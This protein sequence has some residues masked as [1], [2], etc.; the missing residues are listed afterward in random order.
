MAQHSSTYTETALQGYEKAI[1]RFFFLFFLIQLLPID[2]AYWRHLF[3]I[4]WLDLQY[5]DIFYL[6]RYQPQ[7]LPGGPSFA[8]W[9]ITA[10]LALVGSVV[11][12]TRDQALSHYQAAYYWLRVALRYRLALAVLAYGF[13]KFFP[14]QAPPPSLSHLNT[15]YGDFSAWKLF[16]L[17][18]GVV[19]GYQSFLGLVEIAG[20]LLLLHR[21]TATIGTLIILPFAGNVFFSNLAYEGGEYVYSAYLIAIAL[22]LFAFDAVRLF[23][24]L[25]L[26]RPT[27]PNRFQ[28][29]LSASWQSTGR[30]ALKSAFILFFVV[31]YGFKTYNGQHEGSYHY[32]RKPGLT[33]LEGLYNVAEFRLGSQNFPYSKSDPL[34]W[35]DVVFEKWNTISIRSNRP[36]TP[37]SAETEEIYRDDADRN[38]EYAGTQG[39]HYYQY[40]ADPSKQTLVLKNRNKN[41]VDETLVLSYKPLNDSTLVLSG[42]TETQDSIY[43][44]LQKTNK[45]YLIHEVQ[46]SGRRGRLKL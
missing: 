19:P 43:A 26:E 3:S 10:L 27:A 34:R 31:L 39:R 30:I 5:R 7:W 17:S 29:V 45:K 24:L 13:I 41:H 9:G 22:Y 2:A 16:S 33:G 46:K 4:H 36:V 37:E 23:N 44:L 20:G 35:Q 8:N 1:F 12:H 32:P 15:A 42:I 38:Y 11:W 40:D 14:L 25:S 21:K 18:L 6:S 28:P